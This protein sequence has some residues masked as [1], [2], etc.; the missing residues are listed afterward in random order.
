MKGCLYILV[1]GSDG[2]RVEEKQMAINTTHGCLTVSFTKEGNSDTWLD[3]GDSML[4]K[5]SR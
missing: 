4:G 2:H 5:G 1:H 3:L